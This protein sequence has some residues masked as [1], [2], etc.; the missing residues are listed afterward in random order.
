ME[1]T[2]HKIKFSFIALHSKTKKNPQQCPLPKINT[3]KK[4]D[5]RLKK[6][7]SYATQLCFKDRKEK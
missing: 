1:P 7:I 6:P 5:N 2:I 3:I 4:N